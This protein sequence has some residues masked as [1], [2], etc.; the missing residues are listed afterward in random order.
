[1]CQFMDTRHFFSVWTV[2]VSF[3]AIFSFNFWEAASIISLAKPK[4]ASFLRSTKATRK[5]VMTAGLSARSAKIVCRYCGVILSEILTTV[6][7]GLSA[8][9]PAETFLLKDLRRRRRQK[10]LHRGHVLKQHL[11][12]KANSEYIHCRASCQDATCTASPSAE[13][14]VATRTVGSSSTTPPWPERQNTARGR[15]RSQTPVERNTKTRTESRSSM[16]ASWTNTRRDRD[17]PVGVPE[18]VS[19]P[20]C[21]SGSQWLNQGYQESMGL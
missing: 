4:M 17:R 18:P 5:N 15:E 2:C 1:M 16:G 20:S 11:H 7:P 13:R 12:F 6:D 8:V 21:M 14:P 9:Y 10:H 3:D 19:P